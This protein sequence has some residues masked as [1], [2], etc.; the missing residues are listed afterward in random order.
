MFGG[1]LGGT[2]PMVIAV[3]ARH[4]DCW[5][6][7]GCR[8]T[9]ISRF[10]N[11][12]AEANTPCNIVLVGDGVIFQPIPHTPKRWGHFACTCTFSF[13]EPAAMQQALQDIER[14]F[15]DGSDGS[16]KRG[17]SAADF[18]HLWLCIACK[19]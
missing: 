14:T 19:K 4:L 12:F 18:G 10:N 13:G 3:I 5:G 11:D 2:W 7:L 6:M 9:R 15:A 17:T 8:W 1:S 16:R